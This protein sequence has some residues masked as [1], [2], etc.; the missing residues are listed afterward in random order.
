MCPLSLTFKLIEI[1]IEFAQMFTVILVNKIRNQSH[2]DIECKQ[3]IQYSI[4][5]TQVSNSF[6]L[7][8]RNIVTNAHHDEMVYWV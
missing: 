7:F 1:V 6:F 3:Y 5:G 4:S 8:L 2:L